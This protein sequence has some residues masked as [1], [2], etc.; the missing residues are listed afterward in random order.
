MR[1][2]FV[3]LH[4]RTTTPHDDEHMEHCLSY[5]RQMILCEADHTLEPAIEIVLADGSRTH[6]SWAEDSV[7]KCRG[8]WRVIAA[9]VDENFESWRDK[10]GSYSSEPGVIVGP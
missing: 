8:D 4:N 2:I 10:A 6:A 3:D 1:Q 9:W 7:H 5:L